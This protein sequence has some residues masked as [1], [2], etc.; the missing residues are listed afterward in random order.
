MDD[1]KIDQK[2][3]RLNSLLIPCAV[4]IGT[5]IAILAYRSL[6]PTTAMIVILLGVITVSLIMYTVTRSK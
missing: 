6:A 1:V 4:I 5:C 3:L 2:T